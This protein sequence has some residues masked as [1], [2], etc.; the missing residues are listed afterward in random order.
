MPQRELE[1]ATSD[2][3]TAEGALKA[4]RDAVRVFGKTDAE[5]DRMISF[6]RII[7]TRTGRA[8]SDQR[9]VILR[10]TWSSGF[11]VQPG[12]FADAL[13]LPTFPSSGCSP[14]SPKAQYQPFA[15]DSPWE[16]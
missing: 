14:M 4:A 15:W 12:N 9:E 2:E 7:R 1:Q 16:V 11:L 6:S 10:I 8:Q 3:Q 5:I 13:L